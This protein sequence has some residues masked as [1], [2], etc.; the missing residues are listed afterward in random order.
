[1]ILDITQTPEQV[2]TIGIVG[3]GAGGVELALTM[4]HRLQQLLSA[5]QQPFTN[6][7]VH[8][9]Q[10]E[11]TLLPGQNRWVRDRFHLLLTQRGIQ[12]HLQEPVCS[13]QAHRV[14][15]ESGLTIAC[16]YIFWVTQAAAPDWLAKAGLTVD[17][18]GFVLVDDALRSLSHPDVFAAGDSATMLHYSRPK[19]GVFAVRQGK[20]LFHNLRRALQNKP[21]QSF[22]PQAQYLSLIGTGNGEA[23]AA[24][25]AFGWQ[26]PLLWRWKDWIDRAFMQRFSDLPQMEDSGKWGVGSGEWGVVGSRGSRGKRRFFGGV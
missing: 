10:K 1:M 19:A 16:D 11:A 23:I 9:F 13:V 22:R 12:L 15:C 2:R 5:A 8:L 7:K 25:G 4:Q 6:L 14:I 17:E 24:R 18:D 21:L 26:S 3:G 20:P